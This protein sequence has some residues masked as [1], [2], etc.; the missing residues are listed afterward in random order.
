MD[1][2]RLSNRTL[3]RIA[4]GL[5]CILWGVTIL[6]DFVP[7][8]VGLLGTGLILLG[9]NVARAQKGLP[10]RGGNTV[11]GILALVWGG[12][13]LARPL[14]RQAFEVADWDWAIFAILLVALGMI[15]L[16]HELLRVRRTSMDGPG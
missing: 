11:P 7:F 3:G 14:L 2:T 4:W 9:V 1:N 13:E 5:L 15:L 10:A 8:G 6:F 12:L 16:A